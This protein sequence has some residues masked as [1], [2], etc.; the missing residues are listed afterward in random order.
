MFLCSLEMF[1]DLWKMS[2]LKTERLETHLVNNVRCPK[3]SLVKNP[4]K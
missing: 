1:F 4:P 3:Y 2:Q